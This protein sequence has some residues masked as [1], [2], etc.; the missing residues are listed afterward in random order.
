MRVTPDRYEQLRSLPPVARPPRAPRGPEMFASMAAK[1]QLPPMS[2]RSWLFHCWAFAHP[3][4][5]GLA[6]GVPVAIIGAVFAGLIG[7]IAGLVFGQLCSWLVLSAKPTLTN[8]AL[9]LG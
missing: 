7:V 9:D 3:V 4:E 1:K 6:I 2:D 8:R 5:S